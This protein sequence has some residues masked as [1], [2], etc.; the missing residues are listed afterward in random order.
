MPRLTA[1]IPRPTARRSSASWAT[2]RARGWSACFATPAGRAASA[3]DERSEL[4]GDISLYLFSDEPVAVRLRKMRQL[5]TAG[6]DPHELRM[7]EGL[8]DDLAKVPEEGWRAR[9]RG[10]GS[11]TARGDQGQRAEARRRR[12]EAARAGEAP[13]RNA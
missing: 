1:P 9:R 12:G 5:L 2:P 7:L 6:A 4:D 8:R 3:I 10:N 11:G 13:L